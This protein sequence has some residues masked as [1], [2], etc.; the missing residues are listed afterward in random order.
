MACALQDVAAGRGPDD[1]DIVPIGEPDD[2]DYGDDDENVEDDEE[3]DE[4]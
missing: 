2:G 1:D 4:D 3:D